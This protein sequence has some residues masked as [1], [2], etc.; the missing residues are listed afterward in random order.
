MNALDVSKE[1][2]LTAVLE[3]LEKRSKHNT[4]V[5]LFDGK[6]S[7]VLGIFM[8]GELANKWL[9]KRLIKNLLEAK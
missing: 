1:I 7:K 4:P 3:E 9:K 2:S 5:L 8:S 6:T